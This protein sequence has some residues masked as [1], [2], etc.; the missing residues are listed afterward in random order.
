MRHLLL[1]ASLLLLSVTSPAQQ[2]TPVDQLDPAAQPGA[3][4]RQVASLP[5]A[6]ATTACDGFQRAALGA[7]WIAVGGSPAIY[8]NRFGS[9]SANAMAQ[10]AHASLPYD[11]AVIVLD[12]PPN[13]SG[14]LVV[15]AAVH[16]LGGLDNLYTK[17]QSQNSPQYEF[18]GYYSGFASSSSGI[19]G[20]IQG[21]PVPFDEGLVSFYVTN[22]GDEMNIEIDEDRDGVVDYHYSDG[23]CLTIVGMGT[24]VGIGAFGTGIGVVEKWELN[25]GCSAPSGPSVTVTGTCPGVVGADLSGLTAGGNYALVAGFAGSLVI[26]PNKP[27]AGGVLGLDPL[28]VPNGPLT[29]LGSADAL[30]NASIPVMG[31][32]SP[33]AC[34]VALLQ[35]VDLTSCAISAA[36]PL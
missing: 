3:R 13:T 36:V 22:A 6:R 5:G 18:I 31:N 34:A 33:A 25:D 21:L 8:A 30:G 15:G 27:C 35:V 28:A 16:G 17:V 29:W 12:M 4:P 23:G 11:S 19:L 24:G 26:P 2:T 20:G 1:A 14:Q 7:D 10:H 32:A 9:V